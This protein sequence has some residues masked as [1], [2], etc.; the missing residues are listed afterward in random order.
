M[1]YDETKD[2]CLKELDHAEVKR[3]RLV[4]SIQVYEGGAPRLRVMV[5]VVKKGETIRF[6]E[7]GCPIADL[8]TWIAIL[9]SAKEAA[10][11]IKASSTKAKTTTKPTKPSKPSKGRR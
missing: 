8:D 2:K 10:S 3:G 5:E 7:F 11:T 4:P 1:A 9:K 6:K